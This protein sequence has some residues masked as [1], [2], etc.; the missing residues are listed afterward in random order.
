MY[1]Q[2]VVAVARCLLADKVPP[3]LQ[4]TKALASSFASPTRRQ[5]GVHDRA[6]K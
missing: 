3:D 6:N 4:A 5:L 1:L 2:I